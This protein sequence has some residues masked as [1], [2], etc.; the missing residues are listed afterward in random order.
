MGALD[1]IG[2]CPRWGTG[3]SGRTAATLDPSPTPSPCLPLFPPIVPSPSGPNIGPKSAPSAHIPN[4]WAL[5]GR[6]VVGVWLR[7]AL[8]GSRCRFPGGGGPLGVGAVGEWGWM[9]DHGVAVGVLFPNQRRRLGGQRHRVGEGGPTIL[10]G[11]GQGTTHTTH[12]TRYTPYTPRVALYSYHRITNRAP[13][14]FFTWVNAYV[15]L[16]PVGVKELEFGMVT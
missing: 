3:H 2:L 10:E 13:P 8:S 1:G 12:H 11:H 15:G 6:S 16:D 5:G 7:E 9:G 4:T 14:H